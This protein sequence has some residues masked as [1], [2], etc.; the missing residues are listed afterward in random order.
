MKLSLWCYLCPN[1]RDFPLLPIETGN[2]PGRDADRDKN[3]TSVPAPLIIC[4]YCPPMDSLISP[5][6]ST[7]REFSQQISIKIGKDL[8]TTLS[9]NICFPVKILFLGVFRL[10]HDKWEEKLVVHG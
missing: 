2:L 8:P 7:T 4:C 10:L 6:K 3:L 9:K 1:W 5:N